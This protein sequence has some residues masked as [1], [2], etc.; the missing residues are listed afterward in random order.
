MERELLG[1]WKEQGSIE[2]KQKEMEKPINE[3]LPQAEQQEKIELII[4]GIDLNERSIVGIINSFNEEN[5]KYQIVIEDYSD[6]AASLNQARTVMQ[7]KAMAGDGP[8]IISFEG[9]SPLK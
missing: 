1:K 9:I 7:T 8:D 3:E 5:T 6:G 4:G 2:N